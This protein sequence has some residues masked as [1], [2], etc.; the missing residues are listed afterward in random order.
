MTASAFR[1]S[2][3]GFSNRGAI[4]DVC[5]WHKADILNA[6]TNVG[7]GGKADVDQPLLTKLDL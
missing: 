1:N 7:F 3:V 5:Y 4:C 2:W 6:L